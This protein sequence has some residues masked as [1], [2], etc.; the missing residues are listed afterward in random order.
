[1]E[2]VAM[3][4]GNYEVCPYFSSLWSS[5]KSGYQS[6]DQKSCSSF[7][8]ITQSMLTRFSFH[9]PRVKS[10][11]LIGPDPFASEISL[12]GPGTLHVAAS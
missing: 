11:N 12:S 8:F 5:R 1:M 4:K 10:G 2:S 6:E 9:L 3:P 7:P